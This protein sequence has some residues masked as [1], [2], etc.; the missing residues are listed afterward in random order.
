MRLVGWCAQ[1]RGAEARYSE[2]Q[3]YLSPWPARPARGRVLHRLLRPHQLDAGCEPGLAASLPK[4]HPARAGS[5]DPSVT[6][7]QGPFPAVG[8]A[9]YGR[10]DTFRPDIFCLMDSLTPL[11][12]RPWFLGENTWNRSGVI[13]AVVKWDIGRKAEHFC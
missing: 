6:E 13:F 10:W 3:V 8:H 4:G 11:E 7:W 5:D 9:A 2:W 1:G 12:L